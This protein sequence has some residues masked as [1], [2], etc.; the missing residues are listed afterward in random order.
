VR[1]LRLELQ[2]FTSYRDYTEIDFGD[3]E[4][5][6]LSGPTGSGKSTIIDA[7]CFALYGSVPRYGHRGIVAP[8]ITQG[9][10]EAKVRLDFSV[11]G[12]RYTAVRVVRRSRVGATTATTKEARLERGGEVIAGTADELTEAVTEIVGLSFE[13]FTKCVVLPQGEFARFLHDKPADR[14]DMLVRLLNLGVYEVMRQMAHAEAVRARS[15][16]DVVAQ[17]LENEFVDFTT[18]ALSDAKARVQGLEDLRTRVDE[19]MPRL[20]ALTGEAAS[21]EAAAEQAES[22]VELLSSL[23]VPGEMAAFGDDMAHALKGLDEAEELLKGAAEAVVAADAARKELPRRDPLADAASAHRRRAAL[24]KAAAV[25]STALK[26][27]E[28]A[29]AKA[30]SSLDAAQQRHDR[31]LEAEAA[32]RAEHAAVHLAA[33]LSEGEPC[34]VCLQR[35]EKLPT[36][37]P[38]AKLERAQA[39][40]E[41]SARA[42]QEAERK[43]EEA[44]NAVAAG[45][46]EAEAD[47]KQLAALDKELERYPDRDEVTEKLAQIDAADKAIDESRAKETAARANERSAHDVIGKLG[48]RERVER[49]RFEKQR[50]LVVPLNPPSAA[51]AELVADWEQLVAWAGTQVPKLSKDAAAARAKSEKLSAQRDDLLKT[52]AESCIECGVEIEGDDLKVAT[53]TAAANANARVAEVEKGIATA[54]TLRTDL[55]AKSLEHEVAAA[56]AQHL[57]ASG[58]ERWLIGEALLRLVEGATSILRELSDDQYSLAFDNNGNFLVTDHHNANEERSAKTLSG[59]ETFLASLALALALS[60]QLVELAAQG[61]ARLEAIFLDEGFGTLDPETLDTAEASIANLAAKGRMVGVITH[62][63]DLAD[64]I[65]LQFRVTKDAR[66]S[67]VERIE[68]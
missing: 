67:T 32:A 24:V 68:T 61:S 27:L 18:E 7:I 66:T 62:V 39:A 57:K 5:L 21:A 43:L 3:A 64:R 46:A 56:L 38:A 35:V 51:R 52:L 12:A 36:H 40:V 29:A 11:D 19:V 28:A 58:F 63:R 45:R 10:L 54:A 13:H 30:R 26:K 14:Q 9:Q 41:K 22:W 65:P 2:G 6:V 42:K 55:E 4:Y 37:P 44:S 1:P 20:E 31:A 59:G 23:E 49:E 48:E 53:V 60:D 17:R 34:P 33:S 16:R 47:A 25:K 8:V 15:E 50:D